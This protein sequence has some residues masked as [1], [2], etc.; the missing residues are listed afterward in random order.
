[1]KALATKISGNLQAVLIHKVEVFTVTFQAALERKSDFEISNLPIYMLW[2]MLKL[3]GLLDSRLIC[4]SREA[5]NCRVK[6]GFPL[7]NLPM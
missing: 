3:E 4:P 1:M 7:S 6:V 2:R 5:Y